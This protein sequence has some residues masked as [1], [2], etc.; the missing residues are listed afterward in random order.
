[1]VG[2]IVGMGAKTRYYLDGKQ[3]SREEFKAV[4]PDQEIGLVGGTPTSGWPIHSE[5]LAV[6][7]KQIAEATASAIKKGVATDFDQHGRPIF[8]DRA[9]RRRYLRTYNYHDN[10]GGYSDG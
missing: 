4:F 6:Q 10:D 5:A 2:K 1:M 3:V 7:R 9:H 8:R